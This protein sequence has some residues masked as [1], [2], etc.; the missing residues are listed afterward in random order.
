MLVPCPAVTNWLSPLAEIYAEPLYMLTSIAPF[1]VAL[2][3]A[4]PIRVISAPLMTKE[5]PAPSGIVIISPSKGT[6]SHWIWPS[7]LEK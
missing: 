1:F 6:W 4:L 7:E 3:L 2:M 5:T